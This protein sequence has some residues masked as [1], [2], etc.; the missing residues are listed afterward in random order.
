MTTK[1]GDA[2]KPQVKLG[3][4]AVK[5]ALKKHRGRLATVAKE[6]DCDLS[7]LYKFLKRKPKMQAYRELVREQT[8]DSVEDILVQDAIN[9]KPYAITFYLKCQA[10][11]RGYVDRQEVDHSGQVSANL[12]VTEIREA[13]DEIRKL[14][15][16]AILSIATGNHD[17]GNIRSNGKPVLGNGAASSNGKRRTS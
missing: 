7:T 9:G 17:P 14:G 11:H 13:L 4:K 16:N 10:K 6:L 3:K 1:T 8:I 2:R 5:K 15:S 12:K